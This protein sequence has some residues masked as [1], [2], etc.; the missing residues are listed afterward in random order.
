MAVELQQYIIVIL[1]MS[2]F[3]FGVSTFTG[4]LIDTYPNVQNSTFMD[5]TSG[6]SAL[7]TDMQNQINS[8]GDTVE[9]GMLTG[10]WRVLTLLT[11][12]I[13]I[14]L[15]LITDVISLFGLPEAVAQGFGVIFGGIIIVLIIFGIVY[16]VMNMPR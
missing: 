2:A 15:A 11:N 10:V 9:I 1:V 6:T 13:Q 4:D 3:V 5:Q 14:F 8:E 16:L 12:V 7:I